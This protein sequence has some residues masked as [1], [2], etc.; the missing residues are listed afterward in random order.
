M[1]LKTLKDQRQDNY[2]IMSFKRK[3][4]CTQNQGKVHT[5]RPISLY[6]DEE[7]LVLTRV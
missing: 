4:K 1:H 2:I 7:G 5:T 6:T 3:R